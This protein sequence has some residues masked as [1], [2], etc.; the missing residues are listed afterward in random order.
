[1]TMS[2]WIVVGGNMDALNQAQAIIP[3]FFLLC[4][5]YPETH[6]A[7]TLYRTR[8]EDKLRVPHRMPL[9]KNFS[10]PPTHSSTTRLSCVPV[11]GLGHHNI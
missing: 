9:K 3:V 2:D 8:T 5:P 1:M 10:H 4:V 11:C 7:L 6:R